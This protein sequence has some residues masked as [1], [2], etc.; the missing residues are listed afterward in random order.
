M[1]TMKNKGFTL[2]E[3]LIVMAI[4]VVLAAIAVPSFAKQLETSREASDVENIRAAASEAFSEC[5]T[6]YITD[7]TPVAA[8]SVYYSAIYRVKFTQHEETFQYM[9]PVIEI[10][11][12]TDPRKTDV[13]GAVSIT[14][15]PDGMVGG[16]TGANQVALPGTGYLQFEFTVSEQGDFYL[17]DICGVGTQP[18]TLPAKAFKATATATRTLAASTS[19]Q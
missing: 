12:S 16:A 18:G 1:K 2:A 4:I 8:G 15:T 10:G 9:T 14:Q 13:N 7:N 11:T 17:T 19:M 3:L 5:Y 6:T